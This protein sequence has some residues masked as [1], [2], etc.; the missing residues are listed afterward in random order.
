MNKPDY[1]YFEYLNEL[2]D[3]GIT[4]M[5]GAASYLADDYGLSKKDAR[6][7][8]LAWMKSFEEN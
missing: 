5:F 3:S 4:N 1:W 7:I 6:R 8:V 2:R